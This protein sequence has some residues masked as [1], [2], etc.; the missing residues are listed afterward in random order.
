MPRLPV[1]GNKVVEHRITLGTYERQQLE[2]FI[3]GMQVRNIGMGFG[4]ATD[5]LEALFNTTTGTVGGA[6]VVAWALKRFFG[7]D[8][9]LP[10]DAEDLTEIWAAI[11]SAIGLTPEERQELKERQDAV[12]KDLA[13]E[14]TILPVRLLGV[15]TRIE[16]AITDL[17]FGKVDSYANAPDLYEQPTEYPEVDMDAG[18]QQTPEQYRAAVAA[19]YVEGTYPFSYARYLLV[20]NGMSSIAASTYLDE[21][22]G[23]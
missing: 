19:R 3:D 2:R 12:K 18:L 5:P 23:N 6:F 11:N 10:T 4:A 21:A 14:A 22:M 9:P 8:V 16:Q 20:Q 15:A 7:I 17:L 1:D 13:D